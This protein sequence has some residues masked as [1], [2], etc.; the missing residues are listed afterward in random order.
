MSRI[1]FVNGNLHGHINPTLPVVQELVRRGDEVYYFSTG[2]FQTKI[3]SA[4]AVFLD[5][6]DELDQFIHSMRPHGNHPFY[7]LMEYMLGFDRAVVPIVV[8]QT[9]NMQFDLLIHDIMFG[10]GSILA[11]QMQLPAIASCSSFLI[12]KPPLPSYML[13]PG[14]HPQ[15]DFVLNELENAAREWKLTSLT[16]NDIFCMKESHNLIYTSRMF[17][18]QG[19]SYDDSNCFVGPCIADRNESL[20]LLL[21]LS[22]E[23]KLIYI[24]LGT[25]LN[26]NIDFYHK[27]IDAF[28]NTNYRVVLSIGDKIEVSSL[29]HLPDNFIVRNYVPQLELLK[30]T[31]LMISHGGLN[32]VS[33]ALYY[34]IPII[35]IPLANDQPAVAK[36][37]QELGAGLAIKLEAITPDNL[38]QNADTILSTPDY[39]EKCNQISLSFCQSGGYKK[40]ADYIHMLLS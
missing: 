13:E 40:A 29:Q 24:S 26:N 25:V 9:K 14:F 18:P 31:H 34:G 16:I 28:R 1:L 15:L 23:R 32:S 36:R 30:H 12:E 3:E 10:G 17:Q 4:G 22:D 6:G 5:Y 37:L 8:K 33:E 27:C 21:D 35:A 7:T 2:E 39:Y 11:K 20:E 19:D 38:R